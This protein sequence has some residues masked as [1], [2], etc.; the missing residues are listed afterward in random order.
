MLK[1]LYIYLN[2]S[3]IFQ[4]QVFFRF[5]NVLENLDPSFWDSIPQWV[6]ILNFHYALWPPRSKIND[7][8]HC[9]V[10]LAIFAAWGLKN[11]LWNIDCVHIEKKMKK[12][13]L[14]F[15]S[16][17]AINSLPVLIYQSNV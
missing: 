15:E 6:S 1:I 3:F 2:L 12:Y 8:G 7:L 11:Y 13:K 10:H 17:N 16:Q 9:S 14:E 5:C 4:F